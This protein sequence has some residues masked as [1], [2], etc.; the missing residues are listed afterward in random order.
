MRVLFGHFL[1]GGKTLGMRQMLQIDHVQFA[2][3]KRRDSL[4]R[5]AIFRGDGGAQNIVA[6]VNFVDGAF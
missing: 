6:A 5:L 4:A 1:R 3:F 2:R